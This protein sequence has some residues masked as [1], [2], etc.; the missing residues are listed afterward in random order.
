MSEVLNFKTY[1]RGVR[2]MMV[3]DD[4]QSGINYTEKPLGDGYVRMLLNYDF[5]DDGL[6]LTPRGGY[7]A[8]DTIELTDLAG[9]NTH[10]R[11]PFAVFTSNVD[12]LN[13]KYLEDYRTKALIVAATDDELVNFAE[14]SPERKALVFPNSTAAV[15]VQ[16]P[17]TQ[18]FKQSILVQTLPEEAQKDPIVLEEYMKN[19]QLTTAAT[20]T[21]KGTLLNSIT[22]SNI[23]KELT[24]TSA[25]AAAVRVDSVQSTNGKDFTVA[26]TALKEGG[27]IKITIEQKNS[28]G[29][30]YDPK[31][32][33]NF[34]ATVYAATAKLPEE[35]K[36]ADDTQSTLQYISEGYSSAPIVHGY[37]LNANGQHRPIAA[38][39]NN[40]YYMLYRQTKDNTLGFGKL[41]IVNDGQNFKHKLEPVK[42]MELTVKE[43]LNSGYNMLSEDPYSFKNKQSAG[44]TLEGILPYSVDA[45]GKKELLLSARPGQKITFELYYQ[46]KVESNVTLRAKWEWMDVNG[47]SDWVALQTEKDNDT[48][49]PG[50]PVSPNYAAGESI[51]LEFEP[52][53]T[54]FQLRVSLYKRTG[55][56]VEAKPMKM[57]VMPIY[58]LTSGAGSTTQNLQPINYNLATATGMTSWKQRLVLWGVTGAENVIFT[59]DINNPSYFPYPN[60]IDI[61]DENII[62]VTEYMDSLLV[63]TET[64]I[65]MLNLMEDGLGFT[66][67]LIQSKLSITPSDKYVIQVVKNMMF[68]K[69]DNYYY[70]VVPK[71][72]SLTGELTIAPVSNPMINLLDNFSTAV[73]ETLEAVFFRSIT[74]EQYTLKLINYQNFVDNTVVSNVYTFLISPNEATIEPF[75]PFTFNWVLNYDTSSRAWFAYCYQ[76]NLA[77]L[78]FKQTI[79]DSITLLDVCNETNEA[80]N[81]IRCYAQL[82]RAN[83]LDP[84]D[85]FKLDVD[86]TGDLDR[87]FPNYQYIDTGYREHGTQHKKRFREVQFKFNNTSQKKLDFYTEFMIDEYRRQT[88][89]K[90]VTRHNVDPQDPNYGLI[91][92]EQVIDPTLT[93]AG[94]TLLGEED[95]AEAAYMWTLDF[96]KFPPLSVTKVRFKVSGKGYAPRMKLISFNEKPYEFLNMNWVFRTLYA[97]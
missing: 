86:P 27:P 61:F 20:Y 19:M 95:D 82:L 54:E 70:M 40:S 59:S 69:S 29:A 44:Y 84:H 22:V 88:Y 64:R 31:R 6:V 68:F 14:Y 39:L 43:V 72:T 24:A 76:C 37:E 93:I 41:H 94:A 18:K 2:A 8:I 85:S 34:Y 25:N 21:I 96:S 97:R 90:Y 53:V 28:S 66:R 73:T 52:T 11:Y 3:E 15:F 9:D 38:A 1:E 4:Y 78:P 12:L 33:A 26:I 67:T 5:K 57:M 42:P 13:N 80:G 81:V 51:T 60:N 10:K 47:S 63:F 56:S 46:Y 36:E 74:P 83:N 48:E 7:Q 87:S 45:S 50:I 89:Y 16:D 49:N 77:L 30:S 35:E 91:Y 32:V 58:Q 79:T 17:K 75:E 23:A 71:T 55:T 92:V 62:H 65:Y